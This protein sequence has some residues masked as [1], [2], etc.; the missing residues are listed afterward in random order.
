MI[1]SANP[2]TDAELIQLTYSLLRKLKIKNIMI[3]I[4]SLGDEDC[5]PA[6][7]EKLRAYLREHSASIPADCKKK[8]RSRPL[9]IFDCK[10]EKALRVA[11]NA[12]KIIDNLSKAAH[13]HFKQVLEML[14][15][16]ELP[17]NVNPLLVRGLDYYSRTVF[18]VW[19][20]D[21]S[22]DGE[23]R[24]IA[25]GGGGRYDK[26]V[27]LLGGP[28][29]TSATGV[30][31]GMERLVEM[32]KHE[33]VEIKAKDQPRVYLAQLGFEA[34]KKGLC[35]FNDLRSCGVIAATSFDR[36]SLKSQLKHA[37]RYG[38]D[39]TLILGQKE[40]L[41]GKIILRDM[42]TGNQEILKLDTIAQEVKKRLK[43]KK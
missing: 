27:E 1:D 24:K 21:E 6:Y 32:M 37:D 7:I 5:R 33:G 38:V 34:K 25:L 13:T 23:A 3:Q 20:T 35:L 2:A 22:E 26:L 43:K 30:A 39:Y 28:E 29:E 42:E 15:E 14:D 18:E 8:L 40:L 36:D 19:K 17:Y 16:L 12:P 31:L 4:S 41:E 11:Q 9:A 10:D